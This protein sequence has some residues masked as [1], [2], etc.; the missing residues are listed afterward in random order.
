VKLIFVNPIT[1]QDCYLDFNRPTV[2]YMYWRSLIDAR[3]DEDVVQVLDKTLKDLDC[4]KEY[5]CGRPMMTSYFSYTSTI[6]YYCY[7][8]YKLTNQI[9]YNNYID[10]LIEKHIDNLVFEYEHP[11]APNHIKTVKESKKKKLPPNKFNRYTT[12]DM[13]TGNVVYI[14]ENARTKE[15]I[16][17]NNPNLLDELNAPK[18]K[19]RKKSIKVKKS[20]VPISAMTFSFKKKT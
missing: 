1:E 8:L 16:E 13:F 18:K 12:T 14:Y 20:V 17:S 5:D 11:Y 9:T 19:E 10:K 7:Y 6:S 3:T 15:K 2:D 4:T